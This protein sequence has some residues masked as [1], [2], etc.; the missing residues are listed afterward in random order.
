MKAWL[1][2]EVTFYWYL[3]RSGFQV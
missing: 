3:W 2:F 1:G